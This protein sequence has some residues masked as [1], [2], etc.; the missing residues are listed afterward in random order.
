MLFSRTSGFEN[1][2]TFLKTND[3]VCSQPPPP[4]THT[5][6]APSPVFVGGSW[7]QSYSFSPRPGGEG[8]A[9]P[10]DPATPAPHPGHLG[11]RS[12]LP[13]PPSEP[14]TN[15]GVSYTTER[16]E[17]KTPPALPSARADVLTSLPHP[18]SGLSAERFSAEAGRRPLRGRRPPLALPAAHR[19]C[20]AARGHSREAQRCRTCPTSAPALPAQGSRHSGPK[21]QGRAS[22]TQPGPGVCR[23]QEQG[24]TVRGLLSF[25]LAVRG[26]PSS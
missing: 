2:N 15:C 26:G 14:G 20:S 10:A 22:H 9:G 16:K 18:V 5:H 13:R 12:P 3:V 24:L 19:P 4:P 1:K 17:A 11:G 7:G 25:T 8:G 23:A 6:D 21:S